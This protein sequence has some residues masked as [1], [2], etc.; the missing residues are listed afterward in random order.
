PNSVNRE[1]EDHLATE[2]HGNTQKLIAQYISVSA[3]SVLT[4]RGTSGGMTSQ[5]G[6]ITISHH[7]PPSPVLITIISR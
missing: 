4:S 7:H 5:N 6:A 3:D 2:P 1:T